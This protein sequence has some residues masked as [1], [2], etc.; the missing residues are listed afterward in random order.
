M[1]AASISG[2]AASATV[3][4]AVRQEGTDAVRNYRAAL[5]F[6]SM[7]LE[8]MLGEV[9]PEEEGA[10]VT[11]LSQTVAEAVIGAGGLGVAKDMYGS[12]GAAR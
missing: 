11:T 12:F 1:S 3:P 8:Q 2:A 5:S 7:L 4:A 9:L 6:E 10:S